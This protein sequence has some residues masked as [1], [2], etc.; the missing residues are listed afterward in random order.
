MSDLKVRPPGSQ[1]ESEAPASEEKDLF[2]SQQN[3][4]G[5]NYLGTP[6]SPLFLQ[7][8][9][10]KNLGFSQVVWNQH[11][12]DGL[13]VLILNGLEWGCSGPFLDFKEQGRLAKSTPGAV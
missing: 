10:R 13:Q 12:G 5:D 1:I 11:L 8:W 9:E 6:P 7:V 3:E 4:T 2:R